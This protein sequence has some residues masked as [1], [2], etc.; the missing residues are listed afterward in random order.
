MIL[1]IVSVAGLLVAGFAFGRFRIHR[2]RPQSARAAQGRIATV[3][4][5]AILS[6]PIVT[7]MLAKLFGSDTLGWVCG[8]DRSAR[9]RKCLTT[10]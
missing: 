5:G 4:V 3:I 6:F 1:V 8:S 10:I 2:S 9:A 7:L